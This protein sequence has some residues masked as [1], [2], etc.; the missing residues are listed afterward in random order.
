MRIPEISLQDLRSLRLTMLVAKRHKSGVLG[1]LFYG[2]MSELL[3]I[4]I[5]DYQ[6]VVVCARLSAVGRYVRR[7]QYVGYG[8]V[9]DNRFI[10]KH[11]CWITP[12]G[13]VNCKDYKG[14]LK[15]LDMR[16]DMRETR[17]ALPPYQSGFD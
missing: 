11:V 6:N 4:S 16:F 10:R 3:R 1:I 15:G 2:T 5:A 9:K 13:N 14:L 17:G 12:G 8:R 7:I